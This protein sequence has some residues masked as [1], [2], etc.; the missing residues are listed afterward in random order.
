MGREKH[1]QGRWVEGFPPLI[2]LGFP[3]VGTA[4]PALAPVH[5]AVP[6]KFKWPF[7]ERVCPV[8][9]D[10]LPKPPSLGFCGR[11]WLPGCCGRFAQALSFLGL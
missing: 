8:K 2:A 4:L 1:P 5:R 9:V 10:R 3:A 6:C 7:L 11:L